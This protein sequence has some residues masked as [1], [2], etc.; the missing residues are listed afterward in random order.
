MFDGC[1]IHDLRG[2]MRIKD[3]GPGTLDQFV[4]DNCLVTW[5]RDYGVL[6]V[7]RDD[8]KCNNIELKNSTFSKIRVF[9]TS[10]NN[11]KTLVID[12]CTLNEHTAAGQRM[13][14]WRTVN[15]DS[16]LNGVLIR[17]TIMGPG[18][19]ETATGATAFDGFDGLPEVI[20]TIENSYITS[21][22]DISATGDSITGFNFVYDKTSADLWAD[23][24]NG[25]LNYADSAF[26]G[27]GN[28]GDQRWGYATDDGGVD[29]NISAGA[30][31]G[32]GTIDT[33][34][35]VAGLTIHASSASPVVVDGNNKTV[36]D[37]SFTS[38]MK[39]GGSGSFY[40]D[41][42]PQK[43]VLTIDLDH[44]TAVSVAAMSSSG[45]ADRILNVAAGKMDNLI[46][47]HAALGASLTMSTFN[48]Y[49]GPTTLMLWSPS[50]GVNVYYI[51]T[52]DIAN[53]DSVLKDITVSVGE[54]SPAFDPAVTAYTLLVPDGTTEVIVNGTPHDPNAS[55][56]D[57]DTVDVS[58][59]SGVGT[60]TCVAEDGVSDM[61][62]VVTITV[63]VPPPTPANITFIVD[64][65]DLRT[66]P[67]FGLKG[68]WDTG[69]GVYDAAWT[70]GAVHSMFYD[71]GTH[72]DANIGDNIW[73]VTLP[74]IPDGGANTWEW[75]VNDANGNWLDGNF[76]FTVVDETAQT[77]DPYV[78]IGPAV[79][80]AS[81]KGFT[82][83]PNPVTSVLHI[84][85]AETISRVEV[86]SIAGQQI[87]Q[88]V[89]KGNSLL[90]LS[91]DGLSSG[92]Y[93][94]RLTDNNN[95]IS[96]QK[97]IVE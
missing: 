27:L 38:R 22:L 77:L 48:Y 52:T 14:R 6:T 71:D 1:Y 67:G 58:G 9:M 4:I 13:L 97:L 74:L 5:I 40:A 62:Y 12:G 32:L 25:N 54:L 76:Q 61:E 50:S 26:A 69:S 51:S 7:D 86:I 41:G 45:S 89:N 91:V 24:A 11:T 10:R 34:A 21:D 31:M 72:G 87:L 78:I 81:A 88:E 94:L 66:S 43:R 80:S 59:G 47:E 20:W 57:A 35:R 28:A 92:V 29:W 63:D 44:S 79:A 68:S 42:T 96:H 65:T 85:N 84:D 60:V 30:F 15:Q 3:A 36:G 49:G 73:T 2:V 64:D 53:I 56:S 93:V 95:A 75:G 37:M 39:L 8:W 55:V 23:F 90:R 16:I 70:G 46:G 17:N 83:Y 18:W 33:T 82:I 19:D